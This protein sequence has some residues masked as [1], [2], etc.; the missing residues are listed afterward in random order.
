MKRI[1]LLLILIYTSL[2]I[3]AQDLQLIEEINLPFPPAFSS[4]DQSGNIY[5]VSD[6]GLIIK[7]SSK[8][9]SL[10]AFSPK[11]NSPITSIEASSGVR[12][13]I[14]YKDFQEYIFLDQFL[15]SAAFN[16]F[17]PIVGFAEYVA[18]SSDN[19]LWLVDAEDFSIKKYNLSTNSLDIVSPLNLILDIDDYQISQMREYQNQL[20]IYDMNKGLF[21]FDTYGTLY[22]KLPL[23]NVPNINF[24][25][26]DVIYMK[27]DY[28]VSMNIY[29]GSKIGL[30]LPSSNILHA[31]RNS[32][33]VYL[34]EADKMGIYTLNEGKK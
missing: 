6:R 30:L 15:T 13:F 33:V 17:Y 34:I 21:V 32:N 1:A 9:D 18:V 27:D 26:E 28:L 3:H 2:G 11:K 14:F 31:L 23:S 12:A 5:L 16:T 8:G 25:D 29:S 20:F 19:N 24:F 10:L 4:I 7:Y 22:K